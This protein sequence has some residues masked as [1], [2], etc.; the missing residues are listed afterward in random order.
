MKR[1][2]LADL[3]AIG[4]RSQNIPMLQCSALPPTQLLIHRC[5]FLFS[6]TENI[7]H[8]HR[9]EAAIAT[10]AIFDLSSIQASYSQIRR[11]K[12]GW[13]PHDTQVWQFNY[14]WIM[15]FCI[16]RSLAGIDWFFWIFQILHSQNSTTQHNL[17]KGE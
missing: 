14:S 5:C 11:W 1:V 16:R 15:R 12:Q 7:S 3:L 8:K 6:K 13:G 4:N 17:A 9:R 2:N 10:T